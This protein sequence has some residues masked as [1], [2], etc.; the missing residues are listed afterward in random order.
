M[1]THEEVQKLA[2]LARIRI[3]TEKTEAF[4]KEFDGILAYVSTLETLTLPKDAHKAVGVVHNVF[5][6]DGEPH[7][8]GL[9]T[10]KLTAAFPDTE[11]NLLKVKQIITHE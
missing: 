6:A 4:A 11:G 7:A 5:R 1:A 10:K 3:P 9:Y 2:S 8:S